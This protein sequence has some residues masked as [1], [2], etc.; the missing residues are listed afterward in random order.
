M[1]QVPIPFKLNGTIKVRKYEG[2][3]PKDGEYKEPVE[4]I[5][6]VFKDDQEISRKVVKG[7][8]PDG[9]N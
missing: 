6:I 8:I 3:P 4:T 7:D 2:D 1:T 5:E 9:T